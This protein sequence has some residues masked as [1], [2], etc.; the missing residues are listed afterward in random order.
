MTNNKNWRKPVFVLLEKL[1]QFLLVEADDDL[2]VHID[3]G[4]THLT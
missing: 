4:H 3:D 1:L 2:T